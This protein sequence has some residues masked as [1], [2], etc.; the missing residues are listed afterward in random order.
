MEPIVTTPIEE[1]VT[2]ETKLTEIEV[3][4]ET[5]LVDAIK[6]IKLTLTILPE[7]KEAV[8][9]LPEIR[10]NLTAIP[11]LQEKFARLSKTVASISSYQF[12]DNGV[13]TD[14]NI[15]S[16]NQQKDVA[17]P[18]LNDAS[19]MSAIEKTN[20]N[21]TTVG[22]NN[23]APQNKDI[24]SK[25][26]EESTS[27]PN[28]PEAPAQQTV[29]NN[30]IAQ[31]QS[32][33]QN[34]LVKKNAGKTTKTQQ[35]FQQEIA[36]TSG[37]VVQRFNNRGFGRGV[38]R[39]FS[40]GFGR[41]MNRGFRGGGFQRSGGRGFRFQANRNAGGMKNNRILLQEN[42]SQSVPTFEAMNLK[43]QLLDG[44]REHGWYNEPSPIQQRAIPAIF[45]GRNVIIQIPCIE[46]RVMCFVI[47]LLQEIDPEDPLCQAIVLIPTKD[48]GH[49]VAEILNSVGR[50][51]R[52]GVVT[53]TPETTLDEDLSIISN[54]D[55][56]KQI[57]IA[58]PGR[59]LSLIR[60]RE[61]FGGH[62]KSIVIEECCLMFS[63]QHGYKTFDILRSFPRIKRILMTTATTYTLAELKDREAP[64]AAIVLDESG[65]KDGLHLYYKI[66]DNDEQKLS[67]ICET[68]E[69]LEIE[70]AVIFCRN[71]DT[72]NSLA[73]KLHDMYHDYPLWS[74]DYDTPDEQR[75][76]ILNKFFDANEGIIVV[77]GTHSSSLTFSPSP[78]VINYDLPPRK[79]PYHDRAIC[80][81]G[82]GREGTMINILTKTSMLDLAP[83]ERYY[84]VQS[85][86]LMPP[87]AHTEIESTIAKT[88]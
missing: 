59:I 78:F 84:H 72:V 87:A 35:Q 70:K 51:L 20:E 55:R 61:W 88:D 2:Q 11:E 29:L 1:G 86:Q 66:V 28:V 76:E 65:F 16:T 75:W 5:K 42:W 48:I 18:Q 17:L 73:D 7:L 81:G 26:A 85:E 44:I 49:F 57:I 25:K 22:D 74:I 58:T 68:I 47:A 50:F 34:Q 4:D 53:C 80:C 39:G 3:N 33:K 69:A 54:A 10:A 24:S 23:S 64:N 9:L 12:I 30:N 43:Q 31:A 77:V 56:S 19:L 8:A 71:S 63:R 15:N 38:G 32:Q 27:S 45:S 21:S 67:A 83:L 52:L 13:V 82:Y 37:P 60:T 41:G 6:E 62:I 79:E 40:R 46:Q 36:S 14:N